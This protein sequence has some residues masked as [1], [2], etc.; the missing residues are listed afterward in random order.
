MSVPD[1]RLDT[2]YQNTGLITDNAHA[3][4]RGETPGQRVRL[5]GESQVHK[6]RREGVRG[7]QFHQGL[8]RP[9]SVLVGAGPG[10]R[11]A[12]SGDAR[13]VQLIALRDKRVGRDCTGDDSDAV[14]TNIRWPRLARIRAEKVALVGPWRRPG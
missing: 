7:F 9:I 1:A 8:R 14:A 12:R 10:E 5:R 11:F 3:G 6:V 4:T 2:G 13:C